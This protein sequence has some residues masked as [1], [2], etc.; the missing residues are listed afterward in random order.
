[1]HLLSVKWAARFIFLSAALLAGPGHHNAAIVPDAGNVSRDELLTAGPL[2]GEYELSA[3]AGGN[4]A[5]EILPGNPD[6]KRDE[7]RIKPWT[8]DRRYWQFRGRPLLLLGGSDQDNPFN[9]PNIGGGGL[10]AHLDLLASVGGNYIRNTMSSRDR[11]DPDSD[12]YNDDNLYPFDRDK[13]SGLY[14]LG[15]WNEQYWRQFREFLE[16]TALRDIIV[17]VEI[18]D[19]WDYGEVWGG[20]YAAEAWSAHPFNPKNNVNYNAGETNLHPERWEGYPIFRTIPALDDVPIVLSFQEAFVG[21]LLSVSLEYD[22]ILYCISNESTAGEEWSRYWAGFVHCVAAREG[23]N[24]ELTEMWNAHDL[25][26]PM[27]RRTFDYPELYSFVDVSQNNL[28]DGQVHWD[29]MQAARQMVAEPPRPMNNVKIYG[30]SALGGGI[31]EGTSKFWRNILGGIAACRFHRPGPRDGFFSIGLNELARTQIRSAR[32]LEEVFDVF[33]AEPDEYSSLLSGRDPNEAYLA[34][35]EGQQYAVYFPRGGAVRLDMG[36][37]QGEFVLQWLDIS[38]SRWIGETILTGGGPIE[39]SVPDNGH[40]IV[41][42][43]R[44]N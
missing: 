7:S 22:H 36:R 35:I 16:M 38:N 15:R 27:H 33:R 20:A 13:A 43:V 14:D 41:V 1:M 26:D 9:H 29:N 6:K 37:A 28:R 39:I 42:I 8:E 10:E 25:T 2:S 12:L 23:V 32:M 4:P 44:K 24:I 21:K 40:W 34:Y 19:R 31:T 3:T 5:M 17:Q 30:G 18:W 11:V